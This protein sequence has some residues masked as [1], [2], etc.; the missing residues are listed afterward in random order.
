MESMHF[1]GWL[2]IQVVCIPQEGHMRLQ[3]KSA[4]QSRVLQHADHEDI[5]SHYAVADF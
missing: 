2:E 3:V 5:D 4:V 1:G